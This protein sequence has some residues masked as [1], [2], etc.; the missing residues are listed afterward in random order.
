MT[1]RHTA[2]ASRLLWVL[3]SAAWLLAACSKPAPP[4][5]PVRAVKVVTVGAASVQ[6]ASEYAAEVRPRI[7]SR[8]SF[9]VAGKLLK[10]HVEVG[11]HVKAGQLLAE[12]DPQ[13]FALAVQSAQAQVAVAGT[14]LKLADA[15]YQRY[16]V[17]KVQNFISDAELERR[18]TGLQS[19]RAQLDQAQAQL[20]AQQNQLGY[21]R[22]QADVSGVV[23]GVDAEPGQVVGQVI[24]AAVPVV[25]IAPDGPR[26][27]VFSVPEDR[28]AFIKPGMTVTVKS[29]ASNTPFSGVLREVGSSADPVTRTYLVKVT[30]PT[31]DA[32]ALGSTL[33]VS[34][35]A[36]VQTVHS[37]VLK[38]PTSALRQEGNTTMVWVLEPAS[39]T[40]KAQTIQLAA[41]D[42][43][44][45][46]VASGLQPGTQ[47]VATGVHVLANGQ[48]VTIYE[49]KYKD[50]SLVGQSTLAQNAPDS[51]AK[52]V[53]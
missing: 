2:P 13:D 51:V 5:E 29:V 14:N 30:L 18:D 8:L 12:M 7:E 15:D 39:M 3:L 37:T 27:A 31:S 42:G 28:V 48:K 19:A 36:A 46:V 21:T 47:V 38:L 44:D 25:R 33:S 34:F 45:V 6:T 20:T 17:L 4:E 32:L 1:Y 49:D 26:D 52:S 23:T 10:R 9:R 24:G 16:K 40:V 35:P 11:Q 41:F 22:L 50:K 53:K 43:N